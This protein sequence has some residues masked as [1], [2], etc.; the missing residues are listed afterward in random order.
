MGPL[1]DVGDGRLPEFRIRPARPDEGA[2]LTDLCMRSKQS[3]GYDDAFM[4]ACRE[5]LT[6]RPEQLRA[7]EYWVAEDDGICGCASLSVDD[8][9]RVGQVHTFFVEPTM[10]GHGIGKLLWRK[11]LERA[12]FHGLDRVR[13][14]ADPNAVRFYESIGFEKIGESPSGSIEGRFIPH[15]KLDLK[16]GAA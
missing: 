6:V 16:D 3:N 2:V 15:M 10:R 4:A 5:E 8:A 9:A 1:Q 14:D 7:D 11:L 13:L 12:L